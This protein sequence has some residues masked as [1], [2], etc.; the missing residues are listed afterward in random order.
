MP[1]MVLPGYSEY[2]G[3]RCD[4]WDNTTGSNT[5]CTSDFNWTTF[6]SDMNGSLVDMTVNYT[7]SGVFTMKSTITTTTGKKYNY[8]Y[9]KTL[10]AKP[11]SIT[12]FFV[13]EGSYIDGTGI[14]TDVVSVKGTNKIVQ[15]NKMYNLSGQLV[16]KNYK[17]I[18]IKNGKAII[19]K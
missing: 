3:I 10:A 4:N 14:P 19:N 15:N 1:H 9:T 13:N 2:F 11:A 12:L 17:G 6:T 8:S 5:G 16:N 7:E 18:V